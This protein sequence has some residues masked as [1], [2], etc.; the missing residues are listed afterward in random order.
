MQKRQICMSKSEFQIYANFFH[1]NCHAFDVRILISFA[2]K[3]NKSTFLKVHSSFLEYFCLFRISLTFV[4]FPFLQS[5]RIEPFRIQMIR[6]L[7][8]RD[9]FCFPCAFLLKLNES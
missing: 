7:R 4:L 3:T 5:A 1:R 9:C 8:K 2:N 6:W